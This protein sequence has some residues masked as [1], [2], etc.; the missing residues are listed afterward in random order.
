MERHASHL[1]G[2]TKTCYRCRN[3]VCT[4][5]EVLDAK[6]RLI[7]EQAR[8]KRERELAALQKEQTAG[9]DVDGGSA[10]FSPHGSTSGLKSATPDRVKLQVLTPSPNVRTPSKRPTRSTS[11]NPPTPLAVRASMPRSSSTFVRSTTAPTISK[12]SPVASPK[13][14]K[15]TTKKKKALLSSSI[16]EVDAKHMMEAP[17]TKAVNWLLGSEAASIP[18]AARFEQHTPPLSASPVSTTSGSESDTSFVLDKT[19][20]DEEAAQMV[21]RKLRILAE[22]EPDDRESISR[23]EGGVRRK[24]YEAFE[25]KLV[26]IDLRSFSASSSFAKPPSPVTP[27]PQLVAALEGEESTSRVSVAAAER[28]S[29]VGIAKHMIVLP[30]PRVPAVPSVPAAQP[31]ATSQ[32]DGAAHDYLT[33]VLS[34]MEEQQRSF[35]DSEEMQQ[36]NHIVQY[37]T[38]VLTSIIWEA[39]NRAV[40]RQH[41]DPEPPVHPVARALEMRRSHSPRRVTEPAPAP[42][43]TFPPFGLG[44]VKGL[45]TVMTNPMSCCRRFQVTPPDSPRDMIEVISTFPSESVHQPPSVPAPQLEPTTIPPISADN[46]QTPNAA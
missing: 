5:L 9:E 31:A 15:K 16:R 38:H 4:C 32:R 44:I 40:V 21:A 18:N 11:A 2:H 28:S 6:M 12:V 14:R 39:A 37:V 22:E 7:K 23:S 3:V 10:D 26:E 27:N 45:Y 25:V 13:P 42:S 1:T 29:R 33:K 35:L 30:P 20:L 34:G 43:N 19:T 24:L 17:S 41:I 8:R 36:R 46:Q